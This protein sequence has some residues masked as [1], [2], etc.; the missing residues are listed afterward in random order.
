MIDKTPLP[1]DFE[2]GIPD[3]P[4][5]KGTLVEPWFVSRLP[6]GRITGATQ[7]SYGCTKFEHVW[8]TTSGEDFGQQ[9]AACLVCPPG[10]AVKRKIAITGSTTLWTIPAQVSSIDASIFWLEKQWSP[11]FGIIDLLVSR[12]MKHKAW[13]ASLKLTG[14]FVQVDRV[15]MAIVSSRGA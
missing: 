11:Q 13:E 4:F 7:V 12:R 9:S 5:P 2:G 1:E 14:T 15:A 8:I 3:W 10:A 6:D